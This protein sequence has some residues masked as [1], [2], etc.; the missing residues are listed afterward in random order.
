[1]DSGGSFGSLAPVGIPELLGEPGRWFPGE[2]LP[3]RFGPERAGWQGRFLQKDTTWLHGPS[4]TH[5]KQ[6]LH[7]P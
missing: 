6:L 7:P 5:P 1:M 4:L 2:G 3:G